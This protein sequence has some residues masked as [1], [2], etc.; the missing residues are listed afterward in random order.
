MPATTVITNGRQL[1]VS[2]TEQQ[3]TSTKANVGPNALLASASYPAPGAAGPG[4]LTQAPLPSGQIFWKITTPSDPQ[5]TPLT[6][7]WTSPTATYVYN[8]SV[9]N[10]GGIVP[11][12]GLTIDGYPTAAGTYVFQFMDLSLG[13][14]ALNSAGPS[15]MFR[16]CRLRA[17]ASSPG[18][19]NSQAG[20]YAGN[21]YIH[22]C[23]FG[24][25]GPALVDENDVA[26]QIGQS[27]GFR[28]LRNYIS[29][30]ASGMIPSSQNGI[31][32]V[33]E[34][35]VECI[36]FY[37]PSLHLNGLKW[38]G[39]DTNL[40]C[41]RNCVVFDAYDQLGNQ[42]AQT[43]PIGMIPTF[44]AFAGTGINSDGS[45]GY[46][47]ANNLIGGG[48]FSMYLGSDN[49]ASPVANLVV[50]N[51]QWTTGQYPNGGFFGP[52]AHEPPNGFNNGGGNI[53][54]NNTWADGPN[55]GQPVGL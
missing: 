38:Q 11:A 48:G 51:N 25:P 27:G 33:I 23:D 28:A 36:T 7:L 15:V 17:A 29:Y 18:F 55:A 24:G 43:D 35:L 34:N 49:S 42:I 2:G 40:L 45:M 53:Q 54:T 16:G 47:I 44:G 3:V 19:F 30:T 13:S 4:P 21:F 12:G 10:L 22:F 41:L 8:N 5:M 39:G 52:F 14:F 31:M 9:S 32:D 1:P 50:R 20:N 6:G 37:T 46:T 26:V